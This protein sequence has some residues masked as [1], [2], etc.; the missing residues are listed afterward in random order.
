MTVQNTRGCPA[1][2][3]SICAAMQ[4]C[5]PVLPPDPVPLF[6]RYSVVSLLYREHPLRPAGL[7]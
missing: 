1:G 6:R 2:I 5:Q 4:L 3:I 7:V